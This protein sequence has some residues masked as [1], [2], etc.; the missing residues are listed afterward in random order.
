VNTAVN[1]T[2]RVKVGKLDR[3]APVVISA[4]GRIKPNAVFLDGKEERHSAGKLLSGLDGGGQA[5]ASAG[6]QKDAAT[7]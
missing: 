1:I 3:Y 7:V 4:N 2:K 6:G 5:Q